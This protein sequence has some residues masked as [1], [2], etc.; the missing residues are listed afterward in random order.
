MMLVAMAM[1]M[2]AAAAAAGLQQPFD[3]VPM[4]AVPVDGNGLTGCPRDRSRDGG[5]LTH[6]SSQ[7]P[8]ATG[9]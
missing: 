3:L 4:Q 7:P 1:A 6:A 8:P 5:S 9:P 2:V